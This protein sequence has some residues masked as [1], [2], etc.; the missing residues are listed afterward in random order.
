MITENLLS[1]DV[2]AKSYVIDAS[3][4]LAWLLPD[5]IYQKTANFILNLHGLGKLSL[6]APSILPYE[7]INGIKTSVLRKRIN[8][9]IA[10]QLLGVFK[11]TEIKLIGPDEENILDLSIKENLSAYDSAYA[12]LIHLKGKPLITADKKLYD[13]IKNKKKPVIWIEE[14]K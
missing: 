11:K 1:M 2:I 7:I 13:I 10:F 5:E 4:I 9:K 6:T 14:F 3:V 12:S 8:Q